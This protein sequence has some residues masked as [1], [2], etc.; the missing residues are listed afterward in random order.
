MK[1][2][3][4]VRGLPGSGKT[5]YAKKMCEDLQ[6]EGQTCVWLESSMYTAE[7]GEKVVSPKQTSIIT[8]W[9]LQKVDSAIKDADNVIISRVALDKIDIN[10][11]KGIADKNDAE[12]IVYRLDTHWED[13]VPDAV[14]KMMQK[15]MKPWPNEIIIS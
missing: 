15:D 10:L 7:T 2:V 5:T 13:K 12:F 9:L 3:I 4:L 14:L 11:F 1:K 6:G 8:D